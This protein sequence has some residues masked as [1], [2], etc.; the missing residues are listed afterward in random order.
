MFFG[1]GGPRADRRF[2]PISIAFCFAGEIGLGF[3]LEGGASVNFVWVLDW[4]GG[5]SVNSV[6][7]REPVS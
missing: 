3:K 1:V 2:K 4:G 7:G 6:W 5:E